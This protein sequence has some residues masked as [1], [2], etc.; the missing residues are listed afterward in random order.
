[1]ASSVNSGLFGLNQLY[2]QLIDNLITLESSRKFAFQEQIQTQEARKSAISSVGSKLTSFNRVLVD[3]SSPANN[4]FNLFAAQ[5]SNESA[6]SVSNTSQLTTSGSFNLEIQ[7]LAKADVRVSARFTATGNDIATSVNSVGGDDELDFDLTV[8]GNTYNLT[9]GDITGLSNE[10]VLQA[11]ADQIN[12][13][14]DTDVQATILRETSGSVRL[15]VRSRETGQDYAISFSNSIDADGQTNIAEV[16]ELT[17][18][19]GGASADDNSNVLAP[20]ST[21]GGRLFAL[22]TLNAQFTVDGLAFE[23]SS[24]QINDAITGLSINLKQVTTGTET[25]T[26]DSD[27]D[28][29]L[30]NVNRFIESYNSVISDIRGKTFLNGESGDRGPLYSDRAFRELTFT[31]RQNL[32]STALDEDVNVGDPLNPV[33]P[34]GTSI[35]TILDIGLNVR[36]DGTLF[37]DDSAQLEQVL[38]DN[39]NAVATLFSSQRTDGFSGI[40]GKLQD[41]IDLFIRADGLVTS[42]T[43]GIDDRIQQLN[44]RITQQDEFLARRRDQ[45]RTQFIQLQAISDQASSQFQTLASIGSSFGF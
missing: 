28:S 22:N 41:S 32:I 37:I 9:I 21:N 40:A 15:S 31:L 8:N 19:N 38:R 10:D 42:L 39:P 17:T 5:S 18:D 26:I 4:L 11:V 45:L 24:N 36:Q 44:Q 30:S 23:R 33:I 43:L 27:V 14:A 35:Q 12:D 29:A 16:L 1:M 25:I 13:V 7:Q 34:G 2:E 3:F 20:A 6:F